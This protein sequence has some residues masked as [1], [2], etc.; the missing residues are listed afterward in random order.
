MATPQGAP[1][2]S[3]SAG[4]IK[5]VNLSLAIVSSAGAVGVLAFPEHPVLIALSV[6]FFLFLCALVHEGG[7]ALACLV[8]GR[9]IRRLRVLFFCASPEGIQIS[10]RLSLQC[11]CT[12]SNPK[13]SKNWRIY[14][15]GPVFSLLLA[16]GLQYL[17]LRFPSPALY[18]YTLLAWFI[19]STNLLP[20]R[21]NDI[22]MI[23]KEI[24][25]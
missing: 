10:D 21:G 24:G 15:A 9:E 20:L 7:H 5:F 17:Y 6:P 2:R 25:K 11:C 18:V 13:G 16:M 1:D 19:V 22:L 3:V 12:F 4:V 8:C 14:L 23:L